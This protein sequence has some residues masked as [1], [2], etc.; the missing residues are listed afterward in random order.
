MQQAKEEQELRIRN[1]ENRRKMQL[2]R[3]ASRDKLLMMKRQ[4]YKDV[5]EGI[6]KQHEEARQA[7]WIT[8]LRN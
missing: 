5:K 6:R 3:N 7:N 8:T 1:H 2:S 4:A